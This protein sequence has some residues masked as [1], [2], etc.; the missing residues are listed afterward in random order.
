VTKSLTVT[1]NVPQP[2][3]T[4]SENYI[5][6]YPNPTYSISNI[7]LKLNQNELIRVYIYNN[8]QTLIAQTSQSGIVGQNQVVINLG[9]RPSGIYYIMIVCG[10]ETYNTKI[11]KI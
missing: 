6:A 5:R 2:I 4:T 1:S 9:N 10:R 3:L 8:Q 11:R 7:P